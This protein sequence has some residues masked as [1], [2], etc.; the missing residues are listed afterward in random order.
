LESQDST[1]LRD[2]LEER[3]KELT[4]QLAERKRRTIPYEAELAEIRQAKHALDTGASLSP[5]LLQMNKLRIY[6][7]SRERNLRQVVDEINEGSAEEENELAEIGK[8]KSSIG[9]VP[10]N[11]AKLG[12]RFGNARWRYVDEAVDIPYQSLSIGELVIRALRD[13]FPD[14]ATM[15]QL[16]EFFRDKWGREIDRSSLSPQL[17]RLYKRHAVGRIPSLPGWFQIPV[18]AL[19]G[20]VRA[21]RHRHTKKI[22]FKLPNQAEEQDELLWTLKTHP[23]ASDEL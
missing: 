23:I 15:A 6:L 12:D 14:G 11:D 16:I 22:G 17:S 13:H 4:E 7:E 5:T 2:F 10:A 3:E 21:Y 1:N 19:V 8:V 18:G 9:L 20:D